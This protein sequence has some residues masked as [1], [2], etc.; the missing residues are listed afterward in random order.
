MELKAVVV[1][2]FQLFQVNS[3]YHQKFLIKF[4]FY[5]SSKC[6]SLVTQQKMK[7]KVA[8]TSEPLMIDAK[9]FSKDAEY[10]S[11]YLLS[12]H[13]ISLTAQFFK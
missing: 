7:K 8:I 11:S 10:P 1:F 3:I 5:A 6:I 4:L 2:G 9:F 13:Y 12:I